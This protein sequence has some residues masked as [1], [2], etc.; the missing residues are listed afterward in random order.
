MLNIFIILCSVHKVHQVCSELEVHFISMERRDFPIG[1]SVGKY[2]STLNFQAGTV[3]S[4]NTGSKIDEIIY[5]IKVMTVNSEVG[6]KLRNCLFDNKKFLFWPRSLSSLDEASAYASNC[7]LLKQI[8][9]FLFCSEVS[10]SRS[11]IAAPSGE[12]TEVQSIIHNR[13]LLHSNEAL[14]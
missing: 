3:V 14:P 8:A 9:R 13:E 4:V 10:F 12:Q 11:H 1:T 5:I 7:T 6:S 2:D